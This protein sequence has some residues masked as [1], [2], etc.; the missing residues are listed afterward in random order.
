MVIKLIALITTAGLLLAPVSSFATAEARRATYDPAA[1]DPSSKSRDGFLTFTLKRINPENIDYGQH[2]KE[3]RRVLLHETIN[4]AYFWSNIVALCLLGC[5]FVMISFQHRTQA[6][7]DVGWAETLAE[8]EQ[9]LWRSNQEL[10]ESKVQNHE[11]GQQIENLQR[12]APSTEP[13]RSGTPESDTTQAHRTS[14]SNLQNK[15]SAAPRNGAT[16]PT[17]SH[18]ATRAKATES[19]VQIGLFKPESELMAKINLLSQQL[20]HVEDENKE[21]RRQLNQNGRRLEAEEERNR[22]LKGQ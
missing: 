13:L 2:L 14:G 8:F 15:P 7:R 9:A 17:V 12:P 22:S 16:K 6:R 19:S 4:N 1:G 5:L 3:A 10:R 21:L 11:L 20:T 18:S